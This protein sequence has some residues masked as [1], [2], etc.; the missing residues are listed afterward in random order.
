MKR[1]SAKF[2]YVTLEKNFFEK[3]KR[4]LLSTFKYLSSG[5]FQKILMNTFKEKIRFHR[6][7]YAQNAQFTHFGHKLFYEI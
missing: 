7:V 4:S 6:N 1:S 3:S 5:K 2:K